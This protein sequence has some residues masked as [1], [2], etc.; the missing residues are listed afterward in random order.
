MKAITTQ[1]DFM[2]AEPK[3]NLPFTAVSLC[4]ISLLL[5][6]SAIFECCAF[7]QGL[8]E[9]GP[10]LPSMISGPGNSSATIGGTGFKVPIPE[11]RMN[12]IVGDTPPKK[13]PTETKRGPVSSPQEIYQSAPLH[14]QGPKEQQMER[15][16]PIP[17]RLPFD[18]RH[19]KHEEEPLQDI[20]PIREDI[21]LESEV[22]PTVPET[23]ERPSYR[24]TPPKT[25]DRQPEPTVIETPPP[26]PKEQV[27]PLERPQPRPQER[28]RS[29]PHSPPFREPISPVNITESLPEPTKEI[30]PKRMIALPNM[31]EV[32]AVKDTIRSLPIES[33]AIGQSQSETDL[34]QT[35]NRRA[36]LVVEIEEPKAMPERKEEPA[37]PSIM[38]EETEL[39]T[40]PI[41]QPMTPPEPGHGISVIPSKEHKTIIE[42]TPE[43]E[44]PVTTRESPQQIEQPVAP[45]KE[46]IPSPLDEDST[47]TPELK[48]Y[49]RETAP[50]LEELSLL[51]AR[52]PSLSIADF[53]PSESHTQ[54]LPKEINLKMESM[55][56]DLRIL[57]SKIFSIIP[58]QGYAQYH[59]LIRQSINHTYMATEAFINF[60]NQSRM[61]DLSQVRDHLAKAKEYIHRTLE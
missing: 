32:E 26:A 30:I 29:E 33:V 2:V 49:L 38:R 54:T 6:F 52:T 19:R 25:P 21:R 55:K 53:D 36:P 47:M 10:E 8:R 22:T 34:I 43:K 57:D 31:I 4:F 58:P 35:E 12:R 37:P 61:E 51:M 13:E 1:P 48:R 27:A 3:S 17:M 18:S 9:A 20:P 50:I 41:Y 39:A 11:I 46:R 14:P 56:R 7:A 23:A 59:D 60:A 44:A 45:Q 40:P 28:Q 15:P 42:T 16:G 24:I 5:L